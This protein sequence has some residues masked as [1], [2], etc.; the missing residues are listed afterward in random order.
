MRPA[1]WLVS[2]VALLLAS[3]ASAQVAITVSS[4]PDTRTRFEWTGSELKQNRDKTLF[5]VVE[6]GTQKTTIGVADEA[7]VRFAKAE[8][9]KIRWCSYVGAD[10]QANK[11]TPSQPLKPDGVIKIK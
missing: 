11:C 3:P 9:G 4:S 8:V 7:D 2:V 1:D 6:H 10:M 5:V